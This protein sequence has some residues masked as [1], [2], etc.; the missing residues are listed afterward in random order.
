MYIAD[1]ENAIF[2]DIEYE[3]PYALYGTYAVN[4]TNVTLTLANPP[5]DMPGTLSGVIDGISFSICFPD[6]EEGIAEM[7]YMSVADLASLLS[8]SGS[9]GSGSGSGGSSSSSDSGTGFNADGSLDG[10]WLGRTMDDTSI[11]FNYS[12]FDI[13]K[14]IIDGSSV[15]FYTADNMD[16]MSEWNYYQENPS[17]ASDDLTL[18]VSVWNAGVSLSIEEIMGSFWL[19]NINISTTD[20]WNTISASNIDFGPITFYREGEVPA[21]NTDPDPTTQDP[22]PEPPLNLDGIWFSEE[23]VPATETYDE[24]TRLFEKIVFDGENFSLYNASEEYQN[25][26]IAYW[27]LVKTPAEGYEPYEPPVIWELVTEGTWTNNGDSLT[28]HIILAEGTVSLNATLTEDRIVFSDDKIFDKQE[29]TE[30]GPLTGIW[31][32]EYGSMSYVIYNNRFV[33][34]YPLGV[35]L[36]N[37]SETGEIVFMQLPG[38]NAVMEGTV[39]LNGNVIMLTFANGTETESVSIYLSED[40]RSFTIPGHPA[41]PE[42]DIPEEAPETYTKQ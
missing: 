34:Y 22:I 24:H 14:L 18:P 29:F 20:N 27:E 10:T 6:D 1:E 30:E 39:T 11:Y 7:W 40:G 32:N 9:G 36:G 17:Y 21:G 25:R 42:N 16:D 33:V 3:F 8:S 35:P 13:Y 5:E 19:G 4:G 38:A 26:D 31:T 15:T 2:P 23:T 12:G 28:L 37:D 41:D